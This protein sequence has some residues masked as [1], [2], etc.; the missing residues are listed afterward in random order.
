MDKKRESEKL[1]EQKEPEEPMYSR[2]S[3]NLHTASLSISNEAF[4]TMLIDDVYRF[5]LTPMY[6]PCL[7]YKSE[8]SQVGVYKYRVNFIQCCSSCFEILHF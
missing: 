6:S 2:V 8:I 5:R 3:R 4:F 1:D 7:S